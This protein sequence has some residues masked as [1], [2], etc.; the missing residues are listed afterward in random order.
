MY[1]NLVTIYKSRPYTT[2]VQARCCGRSVC[3]L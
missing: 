2:C 1:L 3:D